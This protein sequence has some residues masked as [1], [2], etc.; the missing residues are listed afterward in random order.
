MITL[1]R[2]RKSLT[3]K[4][5][6]PSS[7]SI[8]NRLL[9]LQYLSGESFRLRNLSLSDD[10]VLLSSLLQLITQYRLRG[11]KGLL[12]IDVKN[13]GTVMRFLTAMLAMTNGNYLLTGSSRMQNR[14]IG[15]LVDALRE[16]GADIEYL[17][18]PGFP[19]LLVKGRLLSGRLLTI[20]P[21][22]SSQ[23]VTALLL[24][25]P[26]LEEGLS[27][28]LYR[29]PA[30]WPYVK[31]TLE[32]LRMTGVQ[33]F[34]QED[35][36]R[37]FPKTKMFLDIMIEPDWSAAS[38]WYC[39]LSMADRGEIVFP[40]LEKSGLQGDQEVSAFFSS[41]GIKTQIQQ[42]GINIRKSGIVEADYAADFRD[43]PDLALPVI[44]ACAGNGVHGRFAGLE[45]L[46][47]KESDRL[48]ALERELGKTGPVLR[49][50]MPGKWELFG[51]INA[52][53]NYYL[54]HEGDHRVAMTFAG[55]ALKGFTV[56]LDEQQVVNK[57]YPGFW[58]D[59]QSLGFSI[60]T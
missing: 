51:R 12:R 27:L 48:Q 2:D 31:M 24:I 58:K 57:S 9:I 22:V 53:G 45:S 46:R 59:C 5:F 29:K 4:V 40:G 36:L 39:M 10:T 19:P 47:L 54:D 3:G 14:P 34:E 49:E 11:E 25:A 18:R 1:T 7:K 42:S 33:V 32:I 60:L 21:S 17:E 15:L 28:E 6:L 26:F 23:F 20:D 50:P 55:L 30:S 56:D 16:L 8:S 44:M 52:P 43:Y 35:I 37:V 41:L 13:A 38:F